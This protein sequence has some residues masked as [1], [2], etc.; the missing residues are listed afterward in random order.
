[1]DGSSAR[2]WDGRIMAIVEQKLMLDQVPA[3]IVFEE[4]AP[5]ASRSGTVLLLHGL[6]ANKEGNV[7]ELRSLARHGFLAVGLDAPGHGEREDLQLREKMQGDRDDES[8][9]ALLR[10]ATAEI[11]GVIDQL[12]QRSLLQGTLGITGISMGGYISFAAARDPRIQAAV[13]ILGSPVWPGNPADSPHRTP[14]AFPPTALLVQNA[15]RDRSVPP[16]HA[17]KFVGG[18]QPLY[19]DM[20][21]RLKYIEYENSEHFMQEEDWYRLWNRTLEWFADYL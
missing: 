19:Q 3:L 8:F 20:P 18:L 14:E 11:G 1:M 2:E 16:H 12:A 9:A 10:E 15:G 7:K 17:R 21:Q 6:F 13:P 4:H 5:R